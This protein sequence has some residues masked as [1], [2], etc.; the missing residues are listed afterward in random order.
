[1]K[2][3]GTVVALLFATGTAGC[4]SYDPRSVAPPSPPVRPGLTS[5]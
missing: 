4:V 2:V 3:R 5:A 1:M